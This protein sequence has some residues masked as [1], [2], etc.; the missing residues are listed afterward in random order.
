M[1]KI[2]KKIIHSNKIL[3]NFYYNCIWRPPKNSYMEILNNYSKKNRKKNIRF[4]Q[5]GA[6]D[7]EIDDPINRFIKRDKW[8]GILIEPQKTIFKRLKKNYVGYPGLIFENCAVSEKREQKKLYKLKFTDSRWASGLSSF[9][10]KLIEL[11]IEA[12]YIERNAKK[13][14]IEL[15]ESKEDYITF[16][17]VECYT[18]EDIIVRNNFHNPD[19]IILDVEGYEEKIIESI[20]YDLISPKIIIYENTRMNEESRKNIE[21]KLSKYN[22][23]FFNDISDTLA[24]KKK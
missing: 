4:I 6:N 21:K 3:F 20:D 15:P 2:I 24:Y 9:D 23:V 17:I 7:G 16:D 13:D 22:Y 12:G 10:K 18:L 14:N 5:I 11:M 8:S 19:L 1:K